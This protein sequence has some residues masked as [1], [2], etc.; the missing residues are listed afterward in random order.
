MKKVAFTLAEVL[1]TLAIIG[2][3]A[4]IT[5][6]SIVANHQKRA[7]ETQFAKAYRT[8]FQAMNLAVAEHGD[9]GSWDWAD[10]TF[11]AEEQENFVKKYFVPYLNVV[12]FCPSVKPEA[13]MCFPEERI[14]NLDGTNH[15]SV[16]IKSHKQVQLLLGDGM[17]MTF[18]FPANCF[19]NKNA[20]LS[21]CTDS[22]GFKKPNVFGYDYHCYLYFPQTGEILPRSVNKAGTYSKETGKFE[23]ES[24]EIIDKKCAEE[25]D[26]YYCAAKIIADGFKMNY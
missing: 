18:Y 11:S 4:A 21:L 23:K 16:G 3:V 9:M 25:R 22:N 17:N 1:I 7:L 20:C 13:G 24:P 6:P 12:K 2:V 8:L 15:G 5:I 26:G 10:K 14:M 19:S